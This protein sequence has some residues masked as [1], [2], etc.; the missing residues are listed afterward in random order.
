[1][2]IHP[3]SDERTRVTAR[4]FYEEVSL[5]LRLGRIVRP[6]EVN[7]CLR[8]LGFRLHYDVYSKPR[9]DHDAHPPWQS[10]T[11]VEVELLRDSTEVDAQEGCDTV[12]MVYPL[13]TLPSSMIAPFLDAVQDVSRCLGGRV[14][15]QGVAVER[16]GQ[17]RHLTECVS[18][19]MEEWGEEPGSESL[20]L[21]I[22]ND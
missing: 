5:E 1:M 3:S 20:V 2:E 4:S 12:C 17:L 10:D 15:L 19:L 6:G 18:H 22:E 9:P 21:M 7:R 11:L 13:A 16:E 8:S 14:C